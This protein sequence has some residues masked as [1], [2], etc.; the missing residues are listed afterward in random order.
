MTEDPG[1][2]RD[3]ADRHVLRVSAASGAVL[4]CGLLP[5][6]PAGQFTVIERLL[7][8]GPLVVVPLGLALA[9]GPDESHRFR[10]LLGWIAR[11]QPAGALAAAASFLIDA[12]PL[13]GAAAALWLLV[14][15]LA[16]LAGLV[17]IAERGFSSA[18]AAL[19]A[20]CVDAALA[21]LAVGGGW[22]LVSRLGLRPLG[23]DPVVVVLTA[24]HFHFAAFAAP[25]LAGLAAGVVRPS[26]AVLRVLS[27]GSIGGPPVVAAGITAAPVLE[28]VGAFLM[29]GGLAVL[30]LSTGIQVL[31][32]F[33]SA[34]ARLLWSLALAATVPSMFL[35]LGF[36]LGVALG[37]PF[38]TIP[39]MAWSHGLLNGL[40]FS[41]GGLL[42]WTLESSSGLP[43]RR[44]GA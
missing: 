34:A 3:A 29:A 2:D 24:V 42:S 25:L 19:D 10:R 32:A 14:A 31:P 40:L 35:A 7:L 13:A 17:R 21:Y 44:L 33:R 39:Q 11:S 22:F 41:A 26:R 9:P 37:R 4:W 6:D 1:K 8:L 23:F 28:P 27:L 38:L 20:L 16:A 36:S 30:A 5:F 43:P 18:F 15:L 12:G